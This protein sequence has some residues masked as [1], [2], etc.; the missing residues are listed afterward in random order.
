VFLRVI[1]RFVLN[2]IC[3]YN[4]EKLPSFSK[5]GCAFRRG[6]VLKKDK[7]ER[8]KAKG[9]FIK[10]LFRPSPLSFRLL[11]QPPRRFA[12][13]LLKKEGSLIDS[14]ILIP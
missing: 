14:N 10:R 11:E 9:L 8:M 1:S 3:D 12:P 2:L 4:S 13:P 7:G 6:V 5:E